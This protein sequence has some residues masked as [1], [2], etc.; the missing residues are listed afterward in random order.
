MIIKDE[1]SLLK[2]TKNIINVPQDKVDD[3]V[4]NE[5]ESR[6]LYVHIKTNKRIIKHNYLD[7]ILKSFDYF[8]RLRLI[9]MPRY[10]LPITYNENGKKIIVNLKY[11]G[12]EE[13]SQI[14]VKTLYSCIIYGDI[15]YKL[16]SKKEKINDN[17]ASIFINYYLS[18]FIRVFGKQFGLLGSY[19]REIPKLKFL[20]SLYVLGS[21]FGIVKDKA[22]KRAA[23]YSQVNYR[24]FEDKL[25][26]YDFNDVSDFIQSLS[27]L[28]V[29]IGINKYR[30]TEKILK[31]FTINFIPAIEDCSRFVSS[32]GASEVSGSKLIPGFIYRYNET[33][34]RKIID[35]SN[36]ILKK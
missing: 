23:S 28:K 10:N 22:Y 5:N 18:L 31:F 2:G 21:Y 12:V 6:R 13:I 33:E 1:F 16:I 34:Y 15:F 30:F 14:D 4:K 8:D 9:E 25:N 36:S 24:E 17:Y 29:M 32:I 20:I 11:F 3:L 19:T 27:D 35:L 7:N 26:K